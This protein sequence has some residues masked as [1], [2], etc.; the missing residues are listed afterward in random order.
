MFGGF[1]GQPGAS[2]SGPDG[3]EDGRRVAL[4]AVNRAEKRGLVDQAEVLR[5]MK[6][7]RN[8][9]VNDY[10]GARAAE[11]FTYCREQKPVLDAVCDR[12]AAYAGQICPVGHKEEAE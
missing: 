12:V 1:A 5:E 8:L 11:I 4:D 10:A 7:V 6:D 2:R 3:I 9:I